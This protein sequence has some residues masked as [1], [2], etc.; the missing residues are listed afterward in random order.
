MNRLAVVR[1]PLPARP[2]HFIEFYL[3]R[4][5][6]LV[7]WETGRRVSPPGRSVVVGHHTR[8]M[9][10]IELLGTYRTFT[11]HLVPTG[12]HR[13]TG[14][15]MSEM[16]DLA[17]DAVDVLGRGADAVREELAAAESL[18]ERVEIAQRFLARC[19]ARIAPWHSIDD[20]ARTIRWDAGARLADL[21]DAS[22]FGVRQFERRFTAAIGMPPKTFL[23]L[24][25]FHAAFECK[26]RD[27]AATWA[28]I[29]ADFGYYDQAHFV[30][31]TKRFAG[32]SAGLLLE[33]KFVAERALET[34]F[35]P[36]VKGTADFGGG[37]RFGGT[38]T[39]T[40]LS[41]LAE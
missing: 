24:C 15:P 19:A 28:A 7:A 27:P 39:A 31:D 33:R 35:L 16:T 12:L 21:V 34:P 26:E 9:H 38:G 17:V 10:D 20:A 29:A 3:E 22:G 41:S 5:I 8:R 37:A 1:R 23:N 11:I 30:R 4:P 6:S 18:L 32:E 25:R 14:I 2:L 13:L 40:P 36:S